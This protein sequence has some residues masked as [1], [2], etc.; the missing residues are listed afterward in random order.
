MEIFSILI[1]FCKKNVNK[2][3][4][5]RKFKKNFLRR[6][7]DHNTRKDGLLM[8]NGVLEQNPSKMCNN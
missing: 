4:F 5:K 7:C 6:R 8:E 2:E 1:E 3:I